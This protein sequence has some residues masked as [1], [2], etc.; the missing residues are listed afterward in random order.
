MALAAVDDQN[1]GTVTYH[2]CMQRSVSKVRMSVLLVV[3]LGLAGCSSEPAVRATESNVGSK[4]AVGGDVTIATD[5]ATRVLTLGNGLTVYLRQNDRPGMSTQMRL[6]INAGSGSETADQ[7][8]VAHFLEHMLFN[9]TE[10]FPNNELIDVLRTFGMEFGADVNAYTSY[11]ETVY[12]LTVPTDD[13]DN[14]VTGLEVLAQWLSAATLTEAAVTGERGVVLDEWR[15]SDQTLDGRIGTALESMFLTGTGYDGRAPIGSDVAIEAMTAAPLRAFYDAWYRPENAAIVVV[16]DFDVDEMEQMVREKFEPLTGR[17]T[18]PA[19]PNLAIAPYTEVEVVVLADP[20]EVQASVELTYPA[21]AV[22]DSTV[23]VLRD[24]VVT[25]LAFDMIANRIADDITRGDSSLLT[26]GPSNNNSVRGLNAPSVYLTA[27]DTGATDASDAI[28]LEFERARRFGFDDNEL[29]RAVEVYRSGVQAGFDSSPTRDDSDFASAFVGNFL[30]NESIGTPDAEYEAYTALL[31]GIST[32]DV[33]AALDA[34]VSASAPHLFVSIPA[35]TPDAP[36]EAQLQAL[37]DDAA[38]RDV[39]PRAQ[40]AAVGDSL[41]TPPDEVVEAASSVVIKDP[42]FFLDATRLVFDNGAVVILNPTDITDGQIALEAVSEGGFSLVTPE[43]VFAAR[44]S[45]GVA[46][47]SGIGD[48]DQ[49]AVDSI[50]S[51]S[52]VDIAPYLNVTSE[53]FSG[54]TTPD[55]LELSLQLIHQYLA[56]P[57]FEQSA[58]DA[59]KASD[60]PYIDDPAADP[61]FAAYDALNSARY[62]NSVYYRLVPTQAELDAVDLATVERLFE[63]RFSNASDWVFALSGDFDLD[64]ATALARRYIGSLDGDGSTETWAPIEPDAPSG[65]IELESLAGSG[66]QASLSLL[67]TVDSTGSKYQYL[68]AVMLTSVLGA[69]LT[70]HIRE[71][72]GASYSP[73]A[74]V[75]VYDEPSATVETYVSVSGAPDGVD[76]LAATVQADLAA[77]ALDGPTNDEYNA[78]LAAMQ[79]QFSYVNN[80]QLANV[81]LSTSIDEGSLDELLGE[82][83]QLEL[84]TKSDLQQYAAR[85]LPADNYIQVIQ[86]PR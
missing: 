4:L 59:L 17:G 79:Q 49:V 33:A 50:L 72:L 13:P 6:A 2:R 15:G 30:A 34:R 61:Q 60:Q 8:G 7:S 64:E 16:G 1:G 75:T 46:T 71:E 31:D 80:N 29:A 76:Q 82:Y 38:D 48:L 41:M 35:E 45:V 66:D 21:P 12:E 63:E 27:P 52:N 39:T 5:P 23:G 28:V 55:D 54:N 62:D 22:Q 20:D 32:D 86:R 56:E 40:S 26:A 18:Q 53:G 69:R 77:L 37:L 19:R 74:Y 47:S 84:I 58:L 73:S 36:T 57:R 83:D 67:Y 81:L 25:Q 9:G 65:V 51:G 44:Y 42:G 70:D 10:Q 68:Q 24:F 11:D 43:E 78:A 3:A 85:L 14:L